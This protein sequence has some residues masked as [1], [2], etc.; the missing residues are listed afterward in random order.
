LTDA[1]LIKSIKAMLYALHLK[2]PPY[3]ITQ[4]MNKVAP[5]IQPLM[6][7][8]GMKLKNILTEDIADDKWIHQFG[9]YLDASDMSKMKDDSHTQVWEFYIDDIDPNEPVIINFYNYSGWEA[10]FKGKQFAKGSTANRPQVEAKILKKYMAK[11]R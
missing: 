8:K 4:I 10:T 2:V 1:L 6:E 9:N 5:I 11:M 3:V 7:N